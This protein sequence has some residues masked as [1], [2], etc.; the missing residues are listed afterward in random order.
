MSDPA[1]ASI[2]LGLYD[3]D[4]YLLLPIH[5]VSQS[6]FPLPF[7]LAAELDRLTQVPLTFQTVVSNG[8]FL[9]GT[10]TAAINVLFHFYVF[11]DIKQGQELKTHCPAAAYTFETAYSEFSIKN[12]REG[13]FLQLNPGSIQ[14]GECRTEVYMH[15]R[16]QDMCCS[17]NNAKV[18]ISKEVPVVVF[19][20]L[21]LVPYGG[22]WVRGNV[23]RHVIVMDWRAELA[24]EV[25]E[26]VQN[27]ANSQ[28]LWSR[29][30]SA[31]PNTEEALTLLAS[32]LH[33]DFASGTVLSQSLLFFL[34]W[35]V[36]G[37]PNEPDFGSTR[38]LAHSSSSSQVS[39]AWV[40]R[41]VETCVLDLVRYMRYL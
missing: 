34:A 40:A 15:P 27:G 11:Y 3:Q 32:T 23:T 19:Y 17:P 9:L 35:R 26:I 37:C 21:C 31:L 36:S 18:L 41:L 38:Y 6:S 8:D 25:L 2:S 5:F 29:L 7:T 10:G 14:Q 39:A 1:S 13:D 4:L 16:D 33:S 12:K 22:T 30:I 20:T 24:R 28:N